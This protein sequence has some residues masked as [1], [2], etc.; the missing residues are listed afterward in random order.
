MAQFYRWYNA[1]ALSPLVVAP[2][3]MAR[4]FRHRPASLAEWAARQDWNDPRDPA[5][6]TRLAGMA[7]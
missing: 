6:A 5:L 1:Q 2:G 7:R 3:D 4:H